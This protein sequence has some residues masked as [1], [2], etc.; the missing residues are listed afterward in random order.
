MALQALNGFSVVAPKLNIVLLC[1]ESSP[2]E[3]WSPEEQ[4]EAE[5]RTLRTLLCEGI[6]FSRAFTN[7]PGTIEALASLFSG[8]APAA[9]GI[10][11]ESP[12]WPSDLPDL[13]RLLASV[14]Y[15]TVG[16]CPV[17]AVAE[18]VRARD[19]FQWVL[20]SR[21]GNALVARAWSFG[22]RLAGQWLGR[23]KALAQ[24]T[25]L[26]FFRWLDRQRSSQPFFAWLYFPEN[27]TP[28]TDPSGTAK[29]A[30]P[31]S[32]MVKLIGAVVTALTQRELWD[33]T[34]L[35]VTALRGAAH[36]SQKVDSLAE[37]IV[38]IPLLLR[39]P[40][41]A[42]GGF[43][44]EEFCQLSDVCPTLLHLAGCGEEHWPP[45]CGRAL[46]CGDRATAGPKAVVV[47]EY[48]RSST[49][50]LHAFAGRRRLLRTSRYRFV[51]R[52]DEAPEL[53]ELVATSG[54]PRDLALCRPDVAAALRAELF[55]WL[56]V[57]QRSSRQRVT[58][59][60][61]EKVDREAAV[62]GS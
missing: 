30:H 43:V 36:G 54:Q 28:G 3:L 25:N 5:D 62:I 22:H 34:A 14:G 37:E 53:Y 4:D 10:T 51:W 35:V 15:K 19:R 23:G 52:S 48:R 2:S 44:V 50:K 20:T 57:Q 11:S 38:R 1:F 42:P 17:D 55:D 21:W 61:A 58:E 33:D 59:V 26:W 39:L 7:S 46:V 49:A 13:A 8:L 6:R 16:V 41:G 56:A 9:H 24:R 40:A 45:G 12:H 27:G 47:E 31:A 29:G 32:V 60:A 18:Q